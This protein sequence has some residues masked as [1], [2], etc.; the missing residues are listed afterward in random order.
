MCLGIPGQV[1]QMLDGY[2]GQLALV[3]VAGERRR[4]NV[5][6]LSDETFSPGDWVIIHMGFAVEKTDRD[7]ARQ[8]MAGLELIGG[9]GFDPTVGPGGG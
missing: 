2:E 6:M 1:I 8:A 9:G 3:D 5:G 4:V 7:G